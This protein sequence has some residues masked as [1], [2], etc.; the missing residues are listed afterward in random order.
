M[1]SFSPPGPLLLRLSMELRRVRL[2]SAEDNPALR[3]VTDVE[4]A[5][6][7]GRGRLAAW[8]RGQWQ[9]PDYTLIT[10][11]LDHYGT[12][13]PDR[14]LI[15]TLVDEA[16]RTPWYNKYKD[17]F[18]SAYPGF[19]AAAS[20]LRLIELMRVPG[21]FQ[22]AE[23]A[24]HMVRSGQALSDDV[25]QQRVEARLAR[26]NAIL[27]REEPP[28]ISVVI[29]ESALRKRVGGPKVMADQA[30]HLFELSVR[31][32]IQLQVLPDESGPYLAMHSSFV[33]L[34]FPYG[35]PPSMVFV[36]LASHDLY[37]D[38]PSEVQRHTLVFNQASLLA[39][40]PEQTRA[41][42]ATRVDQLEQR[43]GDH[44]P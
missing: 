3:N 26:Q 30:R 22:T 17:A 28:Q 14:Q 12:A 2:E 1:P 36:E 8:E 10:V 6:R 44:G 42:L 29:D 13:D 27:N 31:G 38:G 16:R 32:H 43:K 5:L 23:Y 39:L 4:K 19:E 37:L 20:Q 21:L 33:M 34:D 40:T 35:M 18:R 24:A 25:V 15:L 41:W 11:L 7:W 9:R